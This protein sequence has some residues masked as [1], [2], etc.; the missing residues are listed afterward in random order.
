MDA[1]SE[2]PVSVNYFMSRACDYR[3]G[4]C[5]HTQTTTFALEMSEIKRGLR[6]LENAGMRKITFSGGE[7]FLYA[8]TRLGPLVDFCKEELALES[9]SI[10]SNGSTIQEGWL[11]K[12]GPSVDILAVSCDSFNPSV[13]QQLGRGDGL[14][15]QRLESISAWCRGSGVMF[16]LNTVVNSLNWQEDMNS[17]VER[18]GP[19]RWKCFQ[20]LVME[21]E[22]SGSTGSLRDARPLTVTDDQFRAFIDRHQR[23]RCLVPEENGLMRTSYLLLDE[24][25]RFL[26]C[27]SGGKI[28][29]PSILDVGV[30]RAICESGFDRSLFVE[31]GGIYRWSRGSGKGIA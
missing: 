10:V 28:P 25:M 2:V 14:V 27:D 19:I 7:P 30:E 17:A 24:R 12:H 15:C 16:K 13:N 6:L 5:F 18:L 1:Q 31:R 22:N 29:G 8:E 11:Q 9:V 26:R 23:Q 21:G 20:V 4:Y 3:C